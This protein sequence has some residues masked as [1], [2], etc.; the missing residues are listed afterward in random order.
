MTFFFLKYV[1]VL[2]VIYYLFT[3]T[4]F[5]KWMLKMEELNKSP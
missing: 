4:N 5:T 3:I 1:F 2:F